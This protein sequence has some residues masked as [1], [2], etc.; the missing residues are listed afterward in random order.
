M[1]FDP[2]TMMAISAGMGAIG[3]M[4]EAKASKTNAANA[5]ALADYTQ[6]RK[7]LDIKNIWG[8]FNQDKEILE[9]NNNYEMGRVQAGAGATGVVPNGSI[10]D[11]MADTLNS[12]FAKIQQ[13]RLSALSAI[14][15]VTNVS[16]DKIYGLRNEER[17]WRMKAD[18]QESMAILQAGMAAAG[19]L[20]AAGAFAQPASSGTLL[21]KG[22]N[23]PEAAGGGSW[24]FLG[25]G[26]NPNLSIKPF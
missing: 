14:T 16:N 8:R 11:F 9:R 21:T 4:Q 12:G 7:K 22:F 18:Q 15:D 5:A 17:N 25:G 23:V 20:S 10:L 2:I 26:Y 1:G 19:G 6:E 13:T 24:T 3:S